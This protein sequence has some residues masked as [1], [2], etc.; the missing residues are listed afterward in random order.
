MS[1]EDEY[2]RDSTEMLKETRLRLEDE[3]VAQ[4]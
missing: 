3:G 1:R 2:T 4:G